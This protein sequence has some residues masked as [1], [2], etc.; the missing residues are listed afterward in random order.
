[1]ERPRRSPEFDHY[2]KTLTCPTGHRGRLRFLEGEGEIVRE[3]RFRDKMLLED[4][5]PRLETSAGSIRWLDQLRSFNREVTGAVAIK[6]FRRDS[7]LECLQCNL[8]WP[9][10]V[11]EDATFE[12]LGERE[13]R[14][15]DTALGTDARIADGRRSAVDSTITL[16]FERRWSQ[17]IEFAW[18]RATTYGIGGH[19]KVTVPLAP[20][21]EFLAQLQPKFEQ[22]V[23]SRL[24]FH[25]DTETF[26]RAT[27][28]VPVPAGSMA[29]I[30][31]H[32]KQIWEEVVNEI[33]MV[34]TGQL[35]RVP[36]RHTVE[37]AFDHE[38]AH[39]DR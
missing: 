34:T 31:I 29:R 36:Y 18:E 6:R 23:K 14:R 9:V 21:T 37:V 10:F 1:M 33:R 32:W 35:L 12:M 17:R 8:R 39:L 26:S 28:D 38:I 27:I 19:A 15:F 11:D 7:R 5:R 30:L 2:C 22:T 24:S 13:R 4:F 3:L 20:G 25:E 16:V